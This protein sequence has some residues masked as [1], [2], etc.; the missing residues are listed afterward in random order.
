M[1]VIDTSMKL[2]V[3]FSPGLTSFGPIWGVPF[4]S[5]IVN[6]WFIVSLLWNVTISRIG[7]SGTRIRFRAN[8]CLVPTV[9]PSTVTLTVGRGAVCAE[10]RGTKHGKTATTDTQA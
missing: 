3:T 6:E 5:L 1:R 4:T 8:C 10:T 2:N 9:S 7:T